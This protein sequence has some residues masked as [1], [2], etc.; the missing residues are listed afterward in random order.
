MLTASP[1]A[2]FGDYDLSETGTVG[3]WSV[4]DSAS[5][6]GAVCKYGPLVGV[7][8]HRELQTIKVHAPHVWGHYSAQTWVGWRFVVRGYQGGGPAHTVYTSPTWKAMASSSS[9]ASFIDASATQSAFANWT[10]LDV[11]VS[12]FFYTPES[13]TNWMAAGGGRVKGRIDTYG[14]K[15]GGNMHG[16]IRSACE[17][18]YYN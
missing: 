18:G 11:S 9:M 14:L 13:S 17:V 4:S 6:P 2:A 3:N 8:P 15:W 5:H 1:V 7:Y 10:F 12:M 16:S